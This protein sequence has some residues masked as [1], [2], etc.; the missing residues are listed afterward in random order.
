MS[1]HETRYGT[2]EVRWRD[3]NNRQRSRTFKTERLAER[4]ERKVRAD[5][6][7]GLPTARRK[8]VS[9]AAVA[10][11]WL[12]DAR[13][14]E[15]N[16]VRI[17]RESLGRILPVLGDDPIATVDDVAVNAYLNGLAGRYAPSTVHRD[18]RAL[19]RLFRVAVARGLI[20]A[21][22]VDTDAVP[23][24]RV[25]DD[26]MM[27][28]TAHQLEDLAAAITPRYRTLILVGGYAG[29]RWGELAGLRAQDVDVLGHRI[30]V[31]GQLSTDGRRWKPETK[32]K[33]RRW[34]S[35][36][37]SVMAELDLPAGGYVWTQPRGGPLEH[38]KF[39]A[40]HLVPAAIKAGLGTLWCDLSDRGTHYDGVTPHDLRHTA[41][42]IA[43]AGGAQPIEVQAMCGHDSI[44]T[45][46]D[47]YGH[48][49]PDAQA[50]LAARVDAIRT[51]A[52]SRLRAV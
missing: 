13:D 20:P 52:R 26:E 21:S 33:R 15:P 17:Y 35:V 30:H 6:D 25:P 39:R 49:F 32:T 29:P 3:I 42:A 31:A 43:I 10:E 51:A 45:T 46:Y 12:A 24:P 4:H 1:I 8:P 28:L 2:W 44:Q 19:K 48:L 40:R 14:L 37:A 11:R 38:T 16:T 23:P 41:V 22:V 34:V 27:F 50:D 9:V 18:Y 7:Q 5:T 36:P 47:R